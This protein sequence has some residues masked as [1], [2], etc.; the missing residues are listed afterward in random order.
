MTCGAHITDAE[1]PENFKVF[2]HTYEKVWWI[3]VD[4][5]I[6]HVPSPWSPYHRKVGIHKDPQ[7]QLKQ[8]Q[9]TAQAISSICSRAFHYGGIVPGTFRRLAARLLARYT[10]RVI[11][12]G[13]SSAVKQSNTVTNSSIFLVAQ[14]WYLILSQ[15]TLS[16]LMGA[17]TPL[18]AVSASVRKRWR[19]GPVVR[20]G[21][22][23]S[24]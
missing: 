1:T 22:S 21:I 18:T 19:L 5:A 11:I 7:R 12:D 14:F 16:A 6:G 2:E 20:D 23:H 4:P 15:L 3:L 13:I 10:F 17:W 8:A 24:Q 9:T